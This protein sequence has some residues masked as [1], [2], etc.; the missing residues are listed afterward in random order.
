MKKALIVLTSAVFLSLKASAALIT[1]GD[2]AAFESNFSFSILDDY[3]HKGY[4]SG[5]ISNQPVSSEFSDIAMSA[6]V[7]ETTYRSTTFDNSNRVSLYWTVTDNRYYCAGCNGSFELGFSD[8]SVST[9]SGVNYVGFDIAGNYDWGPFFAFMTFGD[10]ST[11]SLALP[12]FSGSGEAS[13]F[14]G[15]FSD[16]GITTMHFGNEDGSPSTGTFLIDNLTIASDIPEPTTLSLM[17]LA[18][19][20]LKRRETS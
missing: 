2:R 7:G 15:V 20:F 1:Y 6:V 5:D 19:L 13:T 4:T 18:L 12:L 11:Q 9:A 8:T 3:Q 10:G 16:K 14:W 17:G